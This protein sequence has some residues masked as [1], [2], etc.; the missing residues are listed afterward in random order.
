MY[1]DVDGITQSR[2][3]KG[4]NEHHNCEEKTLRS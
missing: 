2:L 3:W 1:T 4:G